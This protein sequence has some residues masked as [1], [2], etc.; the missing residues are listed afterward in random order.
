[1]SYFT[2]TSARRIAAGAVGAGAV[3]G[4]M[5]FGAA[6][7]QADAAPPAPIP[8]VVGPMHV[9]RGPRWRRRGHGHGGGGHGGLAATAVGAT[10]AAWGGH[11]GWGHGG[12]G[13]GGCGRGGWGRRRHLVG[14]TAV[15]GHLASATPSCTTAGGEP[16]TGGT[17][18]PRPWTDGASR[19][20]GRLAPPLDKTGPAGFR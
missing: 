2:L 10:A 7:A 6:H 4:A 9:A 15:R 16:A 19:P 8:A 3:A 1:M 5:L 13:H 18:W 20:V 12:W 17:G 11:G 14:A